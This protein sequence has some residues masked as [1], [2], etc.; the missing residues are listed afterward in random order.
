MLEQIII[1]VV[2]MVCGNIMMFLM[3]PQER[4]SK[5]L[6]N[7]AT[8]SEEWQK[9][10]K[11]ENAQKEKLDTKIDSLYE[12]LSEI[13]NE[14]TSLHEQITEIKIENTKLKMLKCEK[15]ACPHRQPPT[16]Y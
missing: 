5:D 8:Q 1:A 11:E 2:G 9:L 12:E 15:P 14:N 10:Y 4:K 6:A 7:E 13:R 3:L 16:G